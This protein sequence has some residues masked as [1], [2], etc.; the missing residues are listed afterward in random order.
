MEVIREPDEQLHWSSAKCAPEWGGY[1]VISLF[2]RTFLDCLDCFFAILDYDA[3]EYL[4]AHNFS[5]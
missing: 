5:F 3:L 1:I 4:Q 2:Y